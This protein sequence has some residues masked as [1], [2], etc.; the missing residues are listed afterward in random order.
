MLSL[1]QASLNEENERGWDDLY[2]VSAPKE[3]FVTGTFIVE[4]NAKKKS[5]LCTFQH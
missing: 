1:Y 5:N 4:L 3:V 2:I